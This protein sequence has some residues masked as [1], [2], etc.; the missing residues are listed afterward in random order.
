MIGQPKQVELLG[1]EEFGFHIA[2][3]VVSGLGRTSLKLDGLS[4]MYTLNEFVSLQHGFCGYTALTTANA[5]GQAFKDVKAHWRDVR[6]EEGC[7]N[8]VTTLRHFYDAGAFI[9]PVPELRQRVI[10]HL[11]I[12]KLSPAETRVVQEL[13]FGGTNAEIAKK[14]IF[15]PETIKTHIRNSSTRLRAYNRV[16]IVRRSLV[17]GQIE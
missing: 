2:P 12:G 14:L 11:G 17:S 10:A 8:M 15:A 1:V 9:V 7:K 3:G 13:S 4:R 6:E 16:D 5:T